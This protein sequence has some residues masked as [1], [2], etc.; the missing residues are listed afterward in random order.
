[1]YIYFVFL[2]ILELMGPMGPNSSSCGGPAVVRMQELALLATYKLRNLFVLPTVNQC[3]WGRTDAQTNEHT[4]KIYWGDG[5]T[6]R[7][8]ETDTQTH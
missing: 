7:K 1:M 2:Y 6:D 3:P 8:I 5:Q 4:I